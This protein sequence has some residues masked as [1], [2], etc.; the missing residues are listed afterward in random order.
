MPNFYGR[1]LGH[2]WKLFDLVRSP[3]RKMLPAVLTR[4]EA[5]R[6]FATVQE[7]R[8]RTI[9]R[10]IYACGL[11]IGEATTLEV[12]DIKREPS[13]AL[14]PACGYTGNTKRIRRRWL[15]SKFVGLRPP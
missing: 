1:L 4:A 6:L 15:R 12:T 10:L 13:A 14:S 8:F 9:F 3:D 2:D 5:S 11:R 7:P